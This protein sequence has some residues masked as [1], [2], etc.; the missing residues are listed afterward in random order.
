MSNLE[1]PSKPST[2]ATLEYFR[3]TARHYDAACAADARL[4]DIPFYLELAKSINGNVLEVGCG[5]GRILLPTARAGIQI[6]G[7]DFSPEFLAIL[8]EKLSDEAPEVTAKISLYEEDMRSFSIGKTYDLITIPFGPLQHLFSVDDQLAAFRCCN[9][10]LKADGRIAFNLFFPNHRLLDELG[11]EE[12]AITWTDPLDQAVTVRRTF[13]R[14]SV[15]RLNQCFEG[16][17][18]FRSYRG[19]ELVKEERSNVKMSYY[20]Y[21]Q[22]HLLLKS[23]GFQIREEYGSYSKEPISVCKQMIF[24]AEKK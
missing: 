8:R 7:I 17:F 14:T 2:E 3:S 13:V 12:P 10:H 9:N 21:P 20:T 1:R 19:D 16:E 15:D 11:V 4:M 6:D 24:I 18:I 5:T 23:T 22:V